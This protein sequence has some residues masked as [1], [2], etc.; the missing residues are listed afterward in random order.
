MAQLVQQPKQQ[1]WKDSAIARSVGITDAW[2]VTKIY[3]GRAAEWI[4][5]VCMVA[6]I[7]G[8]LPGVNLAPLFTNIVMGV[9]IVTLDI[10]GFGLATMAQNA[11][12]SGF[13]REAKTAHRTAALLITIMMLTLVLFTL[14]IMVPALKPFTSVAENVLILVRVGMIVLYGHVIHGLRSVTD[15]QLPPRQA[16]ALHERLEAQRLEMQRISEQHTKQLS[17]LDTR[18]QLSLTEL[19]QAHERKLETTI[20]EIM[21]ANEARTQT[22]L[23]AVLLQVD[24]RHEARIEAMQQTIT[25]VAVEEITTTVTPL[26]SLPQRTIET[27]TVEVT[28]MKGED[29]KT[30][31]RAL[32][33][34]DRTRSD[35]AI[36]RLM[37]GTP[38]H[39]TVGKY[40][41][42]IKAELLA[43]SEQ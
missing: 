41:E 35:R 33:L 10:A 30:R 29:T 23:D 9:Q 43:E 13:E 39:P 38:S 1:H 34:E 26:L 17:E 22:L 5:F 16:D 28:E 24:E 40:L 11:R 20:T 32:Y 36:S 25:R 6:N 8:I 12:A 2:E 4:L 15:D 3:A 31:I 21:S 18:H 27:T 37:N 7:I 19:S 42:T 14:G